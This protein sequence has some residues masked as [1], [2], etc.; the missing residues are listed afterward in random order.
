MEVEAL[1]TS[2]G[3]G[4]PPGGSEGPSAGSPAMAS[5]ENPM[6]L[7]DGEEAREPR[8]KRIPPS[9]AQAEYNKHQLTHLPFRSWCEHCVR[10]QAADDAHRA[11]RD[12][13]SGDPR[14][15]VDYLFLARAGDRD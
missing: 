5:E 15:R 11:R 4:L 12:A 3:S 8:P 1:G 14:W 10:G 13:D 6:L 2:S 9:A 7:D